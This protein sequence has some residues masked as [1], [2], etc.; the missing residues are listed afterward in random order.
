MKTKLVPLHNYRIPPP[1][2]SLDAANLMVSEGTLVR[3]PGGSFSLRVPVE[4]PEEA[5]AIMIPLGPRPSAR[6]PARSMTSR[7]LHRPYDGSNTD[8]RR[9]NRFRRF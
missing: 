6:G 4:S 8:P 3:H 9:N 7:A 2:P 1:G 5:P